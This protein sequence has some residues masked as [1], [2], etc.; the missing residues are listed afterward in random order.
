MGAYSF[1]IKKVAKT[2]KEAYKEAVERAEY[3]YGHDGYNGTIS[4]TNNYY[5]F[6]EDSHPRWGTKKFDNWEDKILARDN[7]R[8]QKWGA[9]GCVEITGK[10]AKEIKEVNGLKGKRGLKVF[11]FFGWAAS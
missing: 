5:Y 6:R 10:A 3:E 1:G 8:I 4:T 9:C 11:Y 2:P 7:S